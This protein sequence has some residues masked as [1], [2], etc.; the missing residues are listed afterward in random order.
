MYTQTV[1]G[2]SMSET[3]VPLMRAHSAVS[4]LVRRSL[5]LVPYISYL[6][7]AR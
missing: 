7:T 3:N 5:I 6:V 1:G 4:A 2:H